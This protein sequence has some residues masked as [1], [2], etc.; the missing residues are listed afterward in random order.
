MSD[1]GEFTL[2]IFT[3]IVRDDPLS[4]MTF[5]G[6]L[7]FDVQCILAMTLTHEFTG[8]NSAFES[9]WNGLKAPS[10]LLNGVGNVTQFNNSNINTTTIPERYSLKV[11]SPVG[12]KVK[13][14]LLRLINTSFESTFI[15]SIDCHSFW[16]VEADFVPIKPYQATSVLIGIGQRYHVI[17][18]ASDPV[19][20]QHEYWIRTWR[21]KCFFGFPTNASRHYE[22]TGVLRYGDLPGPVEIPN[23]PWPINFNCSD[24]DPSDLQPVVPWPTI[25]PPANDPQ[26]LIG[27]NLTVQFKQN[28]NI[29][30]LAKFSMGGDEFNPLQI[31]F[32][33]PTFL[34][35]NYTGRW[36]PLW[37]VYPE[38]YTDDSFVSFQFLEIQTAW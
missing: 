17:L 10:I 2:S 29:F 9:I 27:E 23:S 19:R 37:V 32:G 13:R 6:N 24:E 28:P 15:F 22:R 16:V 1:W 33:D 21:A 8:H 34:H 30:P 38:N 18:E 26:G 36:P 7:S 25:P 11:D 12:G 3:L 14:Y 31:N 4:S 5:A 35:L 20:D